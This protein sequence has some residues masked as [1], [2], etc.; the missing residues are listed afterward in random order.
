MKEQI[1][2]LKSD[3]A[4]LEAA[5]EAMQ[6]FEQRRDLTWTSNGRIWLALYGDQWAKIQRVE[7][8]QYPFIVCVGWEMSDDGELDLDTSLWSA[9]AKFKTLEQAQAWAAEKLGVEK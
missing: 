9:A 8:A 4:A 6:K 2:Q 7:T 1:E 5:K 3:K